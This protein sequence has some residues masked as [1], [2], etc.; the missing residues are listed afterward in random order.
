VAVLRLA[1]SNVLLGDA[2][3]PGAFRAIARQLT[4]HMVALALGMGRPTCP[5][6][7][8]EFGVIARDSAGS[9]NDSDQTLKGDRQQC[10]RN[11]TDHAK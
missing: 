10:A 7:P 6:L 4:Y 2:K 11:P 1:A 3:N 5:I 8:V 9:S